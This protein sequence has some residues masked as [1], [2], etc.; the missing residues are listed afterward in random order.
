MGPDG[1]GR[2]TGRAAHPRLDSG[3]VGL[4]EAPGL[5]ATMRSRATSA[6]VIIIRSEGDASAYRTPIVG[7]LV[8]VRSRRGRLPIPRVRGLDTQS[9][10]LAAG[11]WYPQAPMM[12]EPPHEK[13]S[14]PC[15][16]PKPVLIRP[17][18]SGRIS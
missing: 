1:P 16:L 13:C 15:G 18:S 14:L 4:R 3:L 2:P 7:G 5:Y 12:I 6:D 8:R 10:P 11:A 17:L 9:D